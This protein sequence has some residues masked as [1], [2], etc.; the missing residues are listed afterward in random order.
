MTLWASDIFSS[1]SGGGA[2]NFSYYEINTLILVP[3]YQQM[4]VHEELTIGSGDLNVDG[5][6]ILEI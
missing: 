4:A 5:Q 3:E 6:V 2:I 1:S